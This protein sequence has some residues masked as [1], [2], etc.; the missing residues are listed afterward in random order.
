MGGTIGNPQ[1]LS[2]TENARPLKRYN[3]EVKQ[4]LGTKEAHSGLV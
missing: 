1:V 3:F 2:A 4:I